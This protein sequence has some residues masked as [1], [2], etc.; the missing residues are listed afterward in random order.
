MDA[1][2]LI[3][4]CSRFGRHPWRHR[5]A[6]RRWMLSP[7]HWRCQREILRTLRRKRKEDSESLLP[8]TIKSRQG[9]SLG[10]SNCSELFW[11]K[12]LFKNHYM[13]WLHKLQALVFQGTSRCSNTLCNFYCFSPYQKWI[14][15]THC[16]PWNERYKVTTGRYAKRVFGTLNHR[17]FWNLTRWIWWQPQPARIWNQA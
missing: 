1:L 14:L 15:N 9:R 16:T 6:R 3:K 11:D 10:C 17:I 12:V 2:V 8:K 4:T 13:P 5:I 7:S